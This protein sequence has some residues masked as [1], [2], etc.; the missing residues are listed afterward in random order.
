MYKVADI[1][2]KE[3]ITE[4]VNEFGIEGTLELIERVFSHPKMLK[5]KKILKS[6]LFKKGKY[7]EQT[8]KI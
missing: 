2:I 6:Y 8:P 4:Y 7:Y 1:Q 3:R 5:T